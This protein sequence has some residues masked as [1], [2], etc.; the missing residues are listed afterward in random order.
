MVSD[1]LRCHGCTVPTAL[2]EEAKH[3]S[4][5]RRKLYKQ[6]KQTTS[7]TLKEHK[8]TQKNSKVKRP[9]RIETCLNT[10]PTLHPFEFRSC[11]QRDSRIRD[12][13]GRKVAAWDRD[14]SGTHGIANGISFDHVHFWPWWT[15]RLLSPVFDR[16]DLSAASEGWSQLKYAVHCLCEIFYRSFVALLIILCT[17][18]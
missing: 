5:I 17:T 6:K 12:C 1:E 9:T 13:S 2:R 10:S 16:S 7:C 8:R 14:D 15:S 4:K 18:S 3:K 11:V